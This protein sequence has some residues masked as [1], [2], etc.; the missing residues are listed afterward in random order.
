MGE[1]VNLQWFGQGVM[2][3]RVTA[4]ISRRR[5]WGGVDLGF[6]EKPEGM[7]FWMGTG[8]PP[9]CSLPLALA[10]GGTVLPL[11]EREPRVNTG[12]WGET[13]EFPERSL[14]YV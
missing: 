7:W 14:K 1:G 3:T 2:V 6:G 11:A 8:E 5:W 13:L 9:P 10:A 4:G 12:F